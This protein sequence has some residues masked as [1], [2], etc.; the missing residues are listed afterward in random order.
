MLQHNIGLKLMS[1]SDRSFL[2]K[3]QKWWSTLYNPLINNLKI[4]SYTIMIYVCYLRCLFHS[5]I[6]VL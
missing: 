1:S 3:D 6:V 4:N 2:N 5:L